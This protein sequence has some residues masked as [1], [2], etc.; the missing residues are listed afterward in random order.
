MP[1][2]KLTKD[3]GLIICFAKITGKGKPV[4]LRM[5][6]DTGCS[7]TIIPTEV[8]ISIGVNPAYSHR[9]TEITTGSGTVVCPIVT[10]PKFSCLGYTLKKFEIV[11][12]DLPT[13][14]PVEGLLGLN[15]LQ[16]AKIILDFPKNV[17]EVIK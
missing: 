11:C 10:I 7:K 14:S 13:E 16:S 17:I 1:K 8:A 3:K 15:F 4:F 2:F 5:A 12:H 6:L 9:T